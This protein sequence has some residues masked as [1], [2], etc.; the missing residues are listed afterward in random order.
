MLTKQ[1]AGRVY[2]YEFCIGR[3]AYAGNGFFY[4][5]DFALGSDDSLYVIS[6]GT[7]FYP[8]QGITKC[9]LNH[10]VI[11]D[12]RGTGFAGGE[13]SWLNSV[14]V[15]KDETAYISDDYTSAIFQ[16][17]KD[18]HFL[19]KW[20]T[21]GPGDGELN[22]PS[23]LEFDKEDNLYIVDGLNNRI[24]KFT[25]D[26]KFLAKWGSQGTSEGQF[27]MPWG[28]DIDKAGDVYVADW[29]NS[30]VQKFSP[31]G[32]FIASFGAPG[33]GAGEL[34]RPTDIAIDDEGDV[35]ITDRG[36]HK[37]NIYAS[38]G[39]YITSFI[40]DAE[41]LSP[42]SQSMLD[43]NPDFIKARK[44]VDLTPEFRF[45]RPVSV[46]VDGQGRF[47][48]LENQNNRIQIYVKE[49]D[50]VDAPFNL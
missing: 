44:R 23:G 43:A 7:E 32:Q 13:S 29:R 34:H 3:I 14:A 17:D 41:N 11:W 36:N 24:Q 8:A 6:R 4:P 33:T 48:V 2:N 30:R 26:G 18:G 42:W 49:Q 22:G 21:K 28:I 39:A 15:D 1:V 10:E 50:F 47:M 35:Y 9:T 37:L 12:D 25:K 38:D 45:R 46:N 27:D 40:G 5:M 16:Y 19:G 31:D 20:G